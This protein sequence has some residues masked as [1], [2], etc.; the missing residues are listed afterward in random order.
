MQLAV[1]SE[2][3]PN[4]RVLKATWQ[5]PEMKMPEAM[6]HGPEGGKPM[7]GSVKV[8]SWEEGRAA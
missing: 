2:I 6:A 5:D 4:R 3:H 1:I 7:L 8:H